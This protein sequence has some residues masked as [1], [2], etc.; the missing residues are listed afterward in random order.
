MSQTEYRATGGTCFI[1]DPEWDAENLM[2]RRA[3]L[4]PTSSGSLQIMD[5]P[6]IDLIQFVAE[7]F[8]KPALIKRIE[9]AEPEDIVL[10]AWRL[11]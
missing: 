10:A 4:P 7:C 6:A 2:I 1:Y 11:S 3:V 8:A 9:K 5:I